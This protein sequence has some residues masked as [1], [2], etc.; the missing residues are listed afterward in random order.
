MNIHIENVKLSKD[1]NSNANSKNSK[2][3]ETPTNLNDKK[4]EKC[5]DIIVSEI[6]TT[7]LPIDMVST[8]HIVI[9]HE[10]EGDLP[11]NITTITKKL[12]QNK[13]ANNSK[14]KNKNYNMDMMLRDRTDYQNLRNYKLQHPASGYNLY[15]ANNEDYTNM[16]ATSDGYFDHRQGLIHNSIRNKMNNNYNTNNKLTKTLESRDTKELYE[17]FNSLTFKMDEMQKSINL[18]KKENDDLRELLKPKKKIEE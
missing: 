17:K 7:I 10:D 18:L 11:D 15:Y 16:S 2:E 6:K 8:N 4:N 12:M 9:T 5:K 1:D 3:H 14:N 13:K